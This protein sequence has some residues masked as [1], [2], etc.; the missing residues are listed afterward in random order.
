[1]IFSFVLHD[2]IDSS[3]VLLAFISFISDFRKYVFVL[4]QETK[5]V[6]ATENLI[7]A[8]PEKKV[9]EKIDKSVVSTDLVRCL[10]KCIC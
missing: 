4:H 9:P 1:M 3:K 7:F 5:S 10:K 2:F 6:L 8:Q